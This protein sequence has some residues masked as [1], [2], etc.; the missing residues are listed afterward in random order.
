MF[1]F[2]PTVQSDILSNYVKIQST[3]RVKSAACLSKYWKTFDNDSIHTYKYL[4]RADGKCK[5]V[6]TNYPTDDNNYYTAKNK[7]DR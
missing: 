3:W 2:P 5:F 1:A 7:S 4:V 6:S